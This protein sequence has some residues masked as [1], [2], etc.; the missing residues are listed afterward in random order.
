M[1]RA[2]QS[3]LLKIKRK[4]IW[5]LVFLGPFGVISL[6]A[7]NYGVRHD[8]LNSIYPD[9][10]VGLIGNIELFVPVTLMLGIAILT[11]MFASIEHQHS[12]WKQILTLPISRLAVY[13]SK[14]I[15]VFILLCLSCCLLFVGSILLGLIL[16]YGTDFPVTEI[17]KMSYFPL[18]TSLPILAFQLWL[19]VT[20][21]N[22]S[23]ALSVGVFGS[24]VSMYSTGLVRT[25]LSELTLLFLG[26]V[27]GFGLLMIS[28]VHFQRK[29]VN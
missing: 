23:I 1:I 9:K 7:V 21:R 27:L 2:M 15:L 12:S 14:Y 26:I 5:F 16:G 17:L 8:Y 24:I 19:A 20:F 22:Q 4:W 10:W 28:L 3:D 29:D 13:F 6:Q 18:L 11:S 25:E